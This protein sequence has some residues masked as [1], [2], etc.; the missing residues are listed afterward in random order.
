MHFPR[1]SSFLSSVCLL[2][3]ST[4]GS[5]IDRAKDTLKIG[6]AQVSPTEIED[7]IRAQPD[8]FVADLCVAGVS[9]GRTSD[10]KVP[11]AWVVL[12]DAG[13]QVG[14]EHTLRVLE[15][16]AQKSLS[17]YKWLRGGW[18]VVDEVRSVLLTGCVIRVSDV[19]IRLADPEEC[20][21][22]G[23]KAGVAGE[24]RERARG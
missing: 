19:V 23:V 13:N 11:R 21:G 1:L 17:R 2:I 15:A 7:V 8:G 14:A 3:S 6:G 4:H 22:Q 9:G 24:V 10:E 20:D 16:W 5:F 12:S 18:E